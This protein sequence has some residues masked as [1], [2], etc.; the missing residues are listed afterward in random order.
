MAGPDGEY[1]DCEP[2]A[3]RTNKACMI[4]EVRPEFPFS[5]QTT[6]DK[7]QTTIEDP[8]KWN[9]GGTTNDPTQSHLE[10]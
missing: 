3:R 2:R 6:D 4:S 7:R 5:S 10:S 8:P 9:E 1:A